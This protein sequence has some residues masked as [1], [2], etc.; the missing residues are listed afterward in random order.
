MYPLWSRVIRQPL[1]ARVVILLFIL[2][3]F[4]LFAQTA[5]TQ[6]RGVILLGLSVQGN[7]TAS[8]DIVRANSGLRVDQEITAE[9]IQKAIQ[10]L[11]ELGL[12]SDIK[13][14]V[15]RQTQEGVFLVIDVTEN[16][17]LGKIAFQG[18]K[19]FK[20][21]KLREEIHLITGEVLSQE[22]IHQAEKT[23]QNLYKDKNYLL[24]TVSAQES[25]QSEEKHTVDLAFKID[26]GRKVK[27]RDIT[28]HGNEHFSERKLRHQMEKVREQRWWK[29]F[30]KVEYS[31]ENLLAAETD[32]VNFYRNN[33]YRD[34]EVVTD[35][36]HYDPKKKWMYIDLWINEGNLYEYSNFSWEGNTLFTSEEL[37]R[38]LDVD[39]GDLYD[40]EKFQAGMENIRS[41]YMDRG[42]LYFQIN[43]QEIPFSTN[44]VRVNFQLQENYQVSV[45]NID[46]VGNTKTK[47]NVIRRE[48]L[49]YPGDIFNRQRLIRSQR[50]VF[51]LNYFSNVV[52]DV[53]PVDD[54]HIDLE[55]AVEEK[56]TDR[57]N[58]S[59]GYS[60]RD[61]LL[62][63]VGLE[64]NNFMGNGQ[65]IVLNYQ[66]SKI[67]QSFQVSFNEP[68]P[69]NRPNPVGFSFFISKRGGDRQ[70][71]L[72]FDIMQRGG[73]VSV[74][75][76]FRWPDNY[77]RGNWTIYADYKKYSNIQD[78]TTFYQWNPSGI[79][80]TRGVR[81]T[82]TL[83]RDSRDRPEFPTQGSRVTLR[84]TLSGG[85]LG[86]NEEYHKHEFQFEWYTPLYWK[87]VLYTDIEMGAINGLYKNS[88][89]PYDELFFMGGSG[90]VYGTALRGYD[91]RSVGPI[92]ANGY[93]LGAKSLLKYSLELR[94]P[95]SDNPTIYGLGFFEAGNTFL[96]IQSLNPYDL[97]RSAGVGFRLYMPMLGI[98]GIDLGYGFDPV[99]PGGNP[100]GW[101]THFIFGQ[102]F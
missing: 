30:Q 51:I 52:P 38:A 40:Y 47:E 55:L 98:L 17:R 90:L 56:Q 53:K 19:K 24:A 3:P 31:Q 87:F 15:D 96:D 13:I 92:S 32:V 25:P 26:E 57:A 27:I 78:S 4:G 72:P 65:Q 62:G 45:R 42:Y 22:K 82:Q 1:H 91:D 9:S 7:R 41:L 46:I 79:N 48:L 43:P 58:A 93:S 60:Q 54:K 34:A 66:R 12:F 74:G 80:P 70:Y 49:I 29:V 14:I 21:K 99:V 18:N 39:S 86:G 84:S 95:I 102:P 81:I 5:G 37:S 61:G 67:Y 28:F 76:R 73:S 63:S 69:F 2:I 75:H 94:F 11:W 44:Q 50:E 85:P 71:Y 88:V 20:D 23:I 77:F 68:W 100:S 89:I 33:G 83:R 36:I 35:S 101:K 16:P 97:K 8:A 6:N 64:F 10:R 59:V